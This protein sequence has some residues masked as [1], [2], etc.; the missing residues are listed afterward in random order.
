MKNDVPPDAANDIQ[1]AV[2]ALRAELAGYFTGKE[3]PRSVLG[4]DIYQYSRMPGECQR[5]VPTLFK[6]LYDTAWSL[7]CEKERFIFGSSEPP[8]AFVP[9]GDGGFKIFATP[10]QAIVFAVY[11]EVGL[12]AFNGYFLFPALRGMLG[13]LSVRYA[14][15]H[16]LLIEQDNN[17]YGAAIINN[18]R[19]LARDALNRFLIDGYTVDWFQKNLLTLESL[20][21][22]T[23]DDLRQISA[24]N[25]ADDKVVTDL[26]DTTI[27]QQG[28]KTVHLQKIG[29][30]TSKQTTLDVYSLM[31]QVALSQDDGR[32]DT[33]KRKVVVSIGNLNPT[34]VSA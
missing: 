22:L 14:L 10:L 5:L 6:L 26:F 15:T 28:F 20:L 2:N 32:I 4:I 8:D 24:L 19:I 29:V 7:C 11:F 16:D 13:A 12:A 23:A 21:T 25:Q 33:A 34:G 3:V 17:F 31:L 27:S 30:V 1:R 9:T 18:A